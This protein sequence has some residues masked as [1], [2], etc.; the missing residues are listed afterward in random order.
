[1]PPRQHW[2]LPLSLGLGLALSG[3]GEIRLPV[4]SLREPFQ[5]GQPPAAFRRQPQEE[6]MEAARLDAAAEAALMAQLRVADQAWIPRAVPLPGGGTRYLYRR[7]PGD[8]PL[9][10]EQLHQ[11][12]RFP[13]TF[14]QEQLTIRSLLT[15]LRQVGVRVLLA[16]PRRQGAAGEWEPRRAL[17]RIRPDVVGKGSREFA[18]VLNHEA[19]HVAQSCRGGSLRHAPQRLGLAMHLD[20]ATRRHLDAPLYAKISTRERELE[21]EAYA[22][23]HQLALSQQLLARFCRSDRDGLSG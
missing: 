3:C 22:N 21:M 20:A 10:L 7:Q 9:S 18:R 17:L 23:Q 19:I 11:L 16:A 13:P 8:P 14:D 12:M 1:M 2:L 5:P 6:L 15:Q 4:S